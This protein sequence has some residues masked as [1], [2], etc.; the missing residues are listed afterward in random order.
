MDSK[1]LVLLRAP[2]HA[3]LEGSGRCVQVFD[4]GAFAYDGSVSY[5]SVEEDTEHVETLRNDLDRVFG[6]SLRF[7]HSHGVIVFADV[8]RTR[9]A[10]SYDEALAAIGDHHVWLAPLPR[11]DDALESLE[12]LKMFRARLHEIVDAAHAPKPV[13]ASATPPKRN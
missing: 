2:L 6:E 11:A 1:A 5:S 7:H 3:R 9:A 13:S 4:D 10:R 12:A 8:V